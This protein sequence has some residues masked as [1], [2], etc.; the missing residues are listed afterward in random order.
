VNFSENHALSDQ[1][2]FAEFSTQALRQELT[3]SQVLRVLKDGNDRIREGKRLNRDL[4]RQI[5]GTAPAQFP[6]GAFLSCMDSRVPVEVVF[7]LGIGDVFS[8]RIAG[9]VIS[10]KVLGSLE[11]ACAIAGAKLIVVMGHTRCGAVSAAIDFYKSGEAIGEKTGCE[12]LPALVEDLQKLLKQKGSITF[13]EK[14]SP[15]RERLEDLIVRENVEESIDTILARS[16]T[17]KRL[18]D[19][20]R[21]AIVGCIYDVKN[22]GIEF[23][24]EIRN[25]PQ[26]ALADTALTPSE[27]LL[28]ST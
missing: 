11:F 25:A 5:S 17:L 18:V 1:I 28:S 2:R 19:E 6:I 27:A 16:A 4:A 22:G 9:H 23:T 12:H 7:D 13:G 26:Q 21:I 14:G 8:T 24:R 15:E 20:G 3:P 10:D